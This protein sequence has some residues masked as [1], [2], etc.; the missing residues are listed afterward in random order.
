MNIAL[1]IRISKEDEID[2]ESKSII[3]QKMYLKNF[4]KKFEYQ[5]VYE[6]IDDGYSG[7]NFNRPSFNKLLRDIENKKIDTVITKDSSRLGRN[8]S[9]V[10]FYLEEY[11]PSKMIRYISIDDNYDS[12]DLSSSQSEMLI[13]K[14]L[15]NDYY[16]KDIS[17]KIK[18]SLKI[19]KI[20]G[21]FTGWKAPYGYKRKKGDYHKLEIDKNVSNIVKEIFLLAY[22]NNTPSTIAKILNE[23]NIDSPA[24]YIKLKNSKWTTKTIKDILENPTY[25]GNLAQG[26]RKKINYKLKQS[27]NIPKQEWIIK[28]NTH[29]PIIDKYIFQE[30]QKK[31]IKSHNIKNNKTKDNSL[32]NLI[33][34]KECNSKIGL[35][36]KKKQLYCVCNNYKKNYKSLK[37]TPHTIN[38]YT[39]EKVITDEIDKE[40]YNSMTTKEILKDLVKKKKNLEEE[41]LYLLTTNITSEES[42]IKSLTKN[43]KDAICKIKEEMSKKNTINKLKKTKELYINIIDKIFLSEIGEVEIHLSYNSNH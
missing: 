22:Q 3:T 8:I 19:R 7:T 31:L 25:I 28:E 17:K 38:Y 30:V 29:T 41:L 24:Q 27:I 40:I 10:T 23:K 20:E 15:F 18:S 37:C 36:R 16:C 14:S 39:L 21:K 5:N 6:Y 9:W 11:F 2:N 4:I 43:L 34:C 1:Y 26:K 42:K 13:F 12:M 35:N 32:I 33:Y